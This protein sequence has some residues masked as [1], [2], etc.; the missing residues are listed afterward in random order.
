MRI[1]PKIL[2][3]LLIAAALPGLSAW[4]LPR[5]MSKR[6]MMAYSKQIDARLARLVRARRLAEAVP[7]AEQ[8]LL[9]R[10]HTL[11]FSH[12]K[13]AQA[14][15]TLAVVYKA[16]R[17]FRRPERLYKR[18]LV[19]RE[20]TLGPDHP[21][22]AQALLEMS[23][24]YI[25]QRRFSKAAYLVERAHAIFKKK[26]GPAHFRT[27]RSLKRLAFLYQS[28][29]RRKK[30]SAVEAKLRALPK[31]RM[32]GLKLKRGSA[33]LRASGKLHALRPPVKYPRP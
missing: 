27:V 20:R 4:G 33:P 5:G 23:S 22:V 18:W 17:N 25:P 11:G 19:N 32:A 24:V 3:L 7:L 9:L 15:A 28:G 26:L 12:P 31:K 30:A 13:V 21:K 1:A 6:E 10:Q 8:S 16:R 14:L 2:A 29:G